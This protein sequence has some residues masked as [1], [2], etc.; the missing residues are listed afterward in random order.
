MA[1]VCCSIFKG[2]GKILAVGSGNSVPTGAEYEPLNATITTS[3]VACEAR[4]VHRIEPL[5]KLA[6]MAVIQ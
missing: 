2:R 6:A 3:A 4:V 1:G 5:A